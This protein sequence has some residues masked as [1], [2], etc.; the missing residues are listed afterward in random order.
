[1][2]INAQFVQSVRKQRSWSQEEL[3]IAA[4]LNLRTVQRIESEAVASLQSKKAIAAALDVDMQALDIMEKPKVKE[5]EYKTME[6]DSNDGFF[7][8]LKK[9]QVPDY[10]GLFNKEGKEGWSLVQIMTPE[11]GQGVWTGKTGKLV[12]IL[13]RE[14]L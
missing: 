2:K 7:S 5:F 9:A 6:I 14:V 13:Q 3:A 1:M 12:A 10:A 4:G 8:G 11:A